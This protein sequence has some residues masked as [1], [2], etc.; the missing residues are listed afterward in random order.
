MRGNYGRIFDERHDKRRL[1]LVVVFASV[2]SVVK[3]VKRVLSNTVTETISE[4]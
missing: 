1:L 3:P 4:L 2:T